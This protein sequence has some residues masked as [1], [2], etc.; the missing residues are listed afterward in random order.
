MPNLT[1]KSHLN[2]T[3][4]T[5]KDFCRCKGTKYPKLKGE[6]HSPPQTP[7]NHKMLRLSTNAKAREEDMEE[8]MQIRRN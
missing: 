8:D 5:L 3:I 7:T 1:R 4:T 2:Y 6:M